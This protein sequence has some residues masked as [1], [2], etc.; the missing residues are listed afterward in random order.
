MEARVAA[1][2]ARALYRAVASQNLLGSVDDD[3]AVVAG[4]METDPRFGK[5]LLNPEVAREEKLALL[6]RVFGDRVTAVTLDFLRLVLT[7][8][9]EEEIPLIQQEFARL[10][11]EHDHVLLIDVVSAREMSEE[12]RQAIVKKVQTATGKTVQARYAVDPALMGGVKV[13]LDGFEMDGTLAGSLGRLR[14]RLLIDVLK[15]S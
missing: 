11:R 5:F 3:L 4:L 12:H 6:G 14:E 9:R 15:Q 8:R 2:Y 1:R 10:V 7:K 13:I